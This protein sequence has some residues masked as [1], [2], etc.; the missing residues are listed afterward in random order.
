MPQWHWCKLSK[1]PRLNTAKSIEGEK[2]KKK[3]DSFVIE[4]RHGCM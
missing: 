2:K 4:A 1:R 3:E